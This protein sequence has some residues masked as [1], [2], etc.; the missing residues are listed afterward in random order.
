MIDKIKSRFAAVNADENGAETIEVVLLT[1]FFVLVVG[2]VAL[3][4]KGKISDSST[5]LSKNFDTVNNGDYTFGNG[6]NP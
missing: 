5:K 1:V 3:L 6:T 4:L 2:G